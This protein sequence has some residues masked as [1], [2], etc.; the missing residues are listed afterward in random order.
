MVVLAPQI[1]LLKY[2]IER[3]CR[4]NAFMAH[5]VG[6]ACKV[7]TGHH[8]MKAEHQAQSRPPDTVLVS[9]PSCPQAWHRPA[10]RLLTVLALPCLPPRGAGRERLRFRRNASTPVLELCVH[11]PVGRAVSVVV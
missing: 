4:L 5:Q 9:Q 3:L 8:L 10:L 2:R 1:I 6:Q 11:G 7:T